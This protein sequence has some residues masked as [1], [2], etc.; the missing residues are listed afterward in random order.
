MNMNELPLLPVPPTEKK[1]LV[2]HCFGGFFWGVFAVAVLFWC[3]DAWLAAFFDEQ[4]SFLAAL[5][6]PG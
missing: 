5:I 4:Q 1:S 3:V 2:A 6:K